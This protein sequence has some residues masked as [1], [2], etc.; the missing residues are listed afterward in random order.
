MKTNPVKSLRHFSRVP[1]RAEVSLHLHDRTIAVH[2]VDI[3]LKGALVKVVPP[4]TLAL[5]EKCRLVLPMAEDGEG[6]EMNGKIVH[7][8]GDHVGIECQDIDIVSLTRLRRLIE[9]N[10]GDAE[11]MNRDL[12]NLFNCR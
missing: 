8:E 11:L 1:F 2:L 3:A 9:L 5:Q 6:V 12:A 4:Q 7:L 10:T